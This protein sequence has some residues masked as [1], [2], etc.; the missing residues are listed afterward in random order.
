MKEMKCDL[1][2]MKFCSLN[3]KDKRSSI[4]TF[5]D[6]IC[7]VCLR[8]NN[9][10]LPICPKCK[11]KMFCVGVDR[12][13]DKK[14]KHLLFGCLECEPKKETDT[15]NIWIPLP[16]KDYYWYDDGKSKEL[17]KVEF[18]YVGPDYPDDTFL[19]I[20]CYKKNIL[21]KKELEEIEQKE[22]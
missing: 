20:G 17:E 3:E 15:Q 16:F 21:K 9:I 11:K 10:T 12:D 5:D 8:K 7:A 14:K 1:C 4:D 22:Y 2:K 6:F 13:F 18:E 19:N